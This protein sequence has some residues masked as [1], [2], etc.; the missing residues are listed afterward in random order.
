MHKSLLAVAVAGMLAA[1]NAQGLLIDFESL[2]TG[3]TPTANPTQGGQLDPTSELNDELPPLRITS[4]GAS[5][6]LNDTFGSVSGLLD[7]TGTIYGPAHTGTN[8]V[9]GLQGGT[10]LIDFTSFVEVRILQPG[11]TFFSQWVQLFG[12]GATAVVNVCSDLNCGV[13]LD[14]FTLTSSQLFS[15]TAP[16]GQEIRNVVVFPVVPAGVAGG[17]WID[18]VTILQNG[19]GGTVPEPATLGLSLAALGALLLRRR[20]ARR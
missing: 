12:T 3:L 8:V 14:S 19:N 13:Q 6:D 17:A 1:G 4:A 15:Y 2:P 11:F 9:A 16:P 20:F 5:T 7:L 18:D 10:T